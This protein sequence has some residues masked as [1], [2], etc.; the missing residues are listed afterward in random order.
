LANPPPKIRWAIFFAVALLAQAVRLPQLGERPMHTDE[1]VN[2]YITG[3]LLGGESFHYDPQDRH[4]PALFILAKPV[5]QLC[6]AKNFSQLTETQL[7]LTPVL[8]GSAM[9]LLFGAA[10]EW[11]G[12]IACLVAALLFAFAPLSLYYS[13]YFIHETLFVAA[14]LGLIL[15]GGRMLKT[16]SISSAALAGFCA[17]LMLACKETAVIHF[18]AL[19]V[20]TLAGWLFNAGGPGV[21]HVVS[22]GGTGL[23]PVVSGV[24]PE[25]ASDMIHRVKIAG[26]PAPGA[27]PGATGLRPVPPER[28]TVAPSLKIVLTAAGVFIVATI[29][30]FTWFGRNWPALADLFRAIPHLAARAGGQG[31]EKAFWYYA[32]LL[33]GGWSGTVFLGL[34]ALGMVRAFRPPRQIFLAGYALL[35]AVIY[36]AIP[37]KTPWL[38]LNL[39][40]PLA[41]LAG[42]GV[43]WLWLAAPKFS[44]RILIL[45]FTGVLGI[46]IGHDTRQRVFVNP[47]DETNPYAYAHTGEDLLRLPARL[48]Q[49]ALENRISNPRIAV[50]AADAWPLPWY[51][52]KFS[53]VGFW[54]PGQETGDADYFITTTDVSGK[55][56][57]RLKNFRLE[58]FGV[59]PNVL[60]VLWTPDAKQISP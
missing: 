57:G 22:W 3:E 47:A 37:Y 51:L 29:L 9:I 1:A 44:A 17:A 16:N 21:P 56:A 58:Y 41:I 27:T 50:V 26:A 32:V 31:H 6:G 30:M 52:R 18:F 46:L 19:G 36:S 34:A 59:R 48:E 14:T 23:R 4:G 53:Q 42:L 55:L 24:A 39:W 11:F 43:E 7:R 49:L 28:R 33:A 13:R 20:A 2:A 10:V 38:A 8:V 60:L 35:I 40:L 45:A 15:S 5:A 25:T 54:Q 12:F